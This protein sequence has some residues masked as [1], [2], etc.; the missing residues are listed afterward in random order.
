MTWGSFVQ[1]E[2]E[3]HVQLDKLIDL[4]VNFVDTAELYPVAFNY[5]QT[6]ERWIGNWLEK[7]REAGTLRREDVYIATK[8]NPAGIGSPEGTPHNFSAERLEA[9]A[10]ASLARLRTDY[11]DLYYLH[12]P[13][14]FGFAGFGWAS[15]GGPE[16][17]A[18]SRT[19]DGSV[20]DIERQVLAVKRLFELRIIKHWALSNEN[21]YGLTM[22][23]LACDRLGVPRPVCVQNDMSLNNRAYEG[24]IAEAA[25][26]FGVVGLPYGVLAGGV[27]TGKYH[28]H[29]FQ[30]DDGRPIAASRMRAR[31][32]FQPR[33]ASPVALAA[34]G[35]YIALAAKFGLKP[36]EMALAWARD[37]W[38][39]GGVII[40]MTSIAQLEDCVNAFKLEPL[41]PSLNAEI[42]AI[43]ERYR[44]P[45]AAY[46][47]KELVLS[48]PWLERSADVSSSH[49]EV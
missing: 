35:E 33:Y 15:W 27:L 5:G 2:N 32:D 42:D 10:R 44:N 25:H 40:G 6:T 7:R 8:S 36:L 16:R 49:D 29:A 23:C 13:S 22:F 26:Q 41:P 34:T 9:S 20:D 48:A 38:Y 30:S 12:F 43:H 19:S 46:A 1:D 31:P 24:D 17:Y 39:N 4:G 21:A 37:R 3:A 47:N 14:R 18:A 11:I 28:N 45:S